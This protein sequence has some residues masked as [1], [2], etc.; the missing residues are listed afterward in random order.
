MKRKMPARFRKNVY[1]FFNVLPEKFS[2]VLYFHSRCIWYI[3]S[4]EAHFLSQSKLVV[5]WIVQEKIEEVRFH[6]SPS[7]KTYLLTSLECRLEWR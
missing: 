7:L 3:P 5:G 1:G 2:I 4:L 6:S